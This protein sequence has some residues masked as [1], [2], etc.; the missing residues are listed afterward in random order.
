MVLEV[1]AAPFPTPL[2]YKPHVNIAE[3]LS[4]VFII[5]LLF[6]IE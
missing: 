2:K 3:Y 5:P 1:A 4:T 6:Q